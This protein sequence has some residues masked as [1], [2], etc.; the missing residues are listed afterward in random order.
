M[1]NDFPKV[2]Y[3]D[4][5]FFRIS[6]ENQ[7]LTKNN[8]DKEMLDI[9]GKYRT[10]LL[11]S[12]LDSDDMPFPDAIVFLRDILVESHNTLGQ[13]WPSLCLELNSL[14][15][16]NSFIKPLSV[17]DLSV[18]LNLEISTHL[19]FSDPVDISEELG[20]NIEEIK[21]EKE[22]FLLEKK[23]VIEHF[24]S[25][26]NDDK[27]KDKLIEN[28]DKDK[29]TKADGKDGKE[30]KGKNNFLDMFKLS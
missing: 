20:L 5:V 23:E 9:I 3:R 19:S 6:K 15:F 21:L 13:P 2:P 29:D 16:K 26:T 14:F 10:M 11:T 24:A 27:K 17:A 28:K 18:L 7:I 22:K 30:G 12:L 8:I 1:L 4:V 25:P